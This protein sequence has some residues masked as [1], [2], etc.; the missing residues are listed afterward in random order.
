MPT[1]V[2]G[3]KDQRESSTTNDDFNVISPVKKKRK[4]IS[5][6]NLPFSPRT[7]PPNVNKVFIT[8]TK[9]GLILI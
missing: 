8:G 4:N 6:G 7:R 5:G 9:I 2:K 3:D 1:K